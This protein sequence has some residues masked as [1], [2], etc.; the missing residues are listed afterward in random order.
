MGGWG[1]QSVEGDEDDDD[2]HINY[3]DLRECNV[4][5]AVSVPGESAWCGVELDGST[6]SK[7]QPLLL[8]LCSPPFHSFKHVISITSLI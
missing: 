8:S 4:L 1:V 2:H 5:W 7:R 6:I 3:D